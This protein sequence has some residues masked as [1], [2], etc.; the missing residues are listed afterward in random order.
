MNI[1]DLRPQLRPR[2]LYVEKL[3]K[4][5]GGEF[6]KIIT[7]ARRVGKSSLMELFR[8]DLLE[9]GVTEDRLVSVNF[10]FMRYD[11]IRNYPDLYALLRSRLAPS[12]QTCYFLDEIQQ[13]AGW[14][15]AV[16]AIK[17]ESGADIYITGSNAWLLSS[18]L[19]TLLSGRY[20]EISVL[21]LS[22][23]EYLDFFPLDAAWS[24]ERK[25]SQYLKYGGFPSLRALPQEDEIVN[26][27]LQGMYN[28]AVVKDILSRHP[29]R[30]VKAFGQLARF[31]AQ[32][33]GNIISPSKIASYMNSND[34]LGRD[35]SIKSATISQYLDLLEKAYIVYP[36]FRYDIK[37]KEL[38]KTLAKYYIVDTGI[39]NMLLGCSDVDMGAVLETVVFFELRRR[40]YSVFTGVQE[41][42]EVDFIALR[43]NDKR[44]YQV[45]ATMLSEETRKR[46]IASLSRINDN[47]EKTILTLDRTFVSDYQGIKQKHIIDFLLEDHIPS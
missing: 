1:Q 35:E 36:S 39:R 32:N 41:S 33:T 17:A 40:G 4:Y 24:V 20:V 27:A 22:F 19:A 30:D 47:Y 6:I 31:L 26:N 14:E 13:V 18:E 34:I 28:T 9:H 23:R 25:F 38:L 7:G 8:R 5:R 46:E 3:R 12:G 29:V 44:Y 11:S 10:E 15:K 43:Q 45:T 37:G 42:R 16:N 2:P 21:P